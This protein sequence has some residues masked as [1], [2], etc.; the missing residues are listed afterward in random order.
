MY[1]LHREPNG[2]YTINKDSELNGVQG[3]PFENFH[4]AVY[5]GRVWQIQHQEDHKGKA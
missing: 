5:F 4:S 2:F 1:Y 3:E